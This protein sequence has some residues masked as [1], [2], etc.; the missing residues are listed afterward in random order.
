MIDGLFTAMTRPELQPRQDH[1]EVTSRDH[2]VGKDHRQ[3]TACD[4]LTRRQRSNWLAALL[5][6]CK[7]S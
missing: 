7:R 4:H 5:E 2:L 1:R 6:L 3:V